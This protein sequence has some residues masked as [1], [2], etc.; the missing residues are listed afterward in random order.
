M[1]D[2]ALDRRAEV[3]VGVQL[4]WALRTR[5]A[6]GRFDPGSR[7]PGVRELADELGV[8]VNTARATYQRL[9]HE[10]LIESRQ[11]S[12]TFVAP[13]PARDPAAS[14]L[15]A[16]AAARAQESGIDPRAVAAAL[17]VE[18]PAE[19]GNRDPQAARRAALRAQ[20]SAFEQAV[21][22]L[23]AK[24]PGLLP[25][26]PAAAL[27]RGDGE[28]RLLDAEELSEVRAKLLRRLAAIQVAIDALGAETRGGSD[29]RGRHSTQSSAERRA[30][31]RTSPRGGASRPAIKPA[32][33]GA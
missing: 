6:D 28:A 3:P 14:A 16:R 4:L 26:E 8:N 19:R 21:A 32:T 5:I 31:P 25:R 27:P 18:P 9:E 12:G 10:G 2:F 24:H 20:I 13:S 17:Y 33:A 11:G 23:E 22:E 15:A 1:L 29:G 30:R 7:L